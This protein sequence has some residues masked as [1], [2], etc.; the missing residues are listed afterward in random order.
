M[1]KLLSLPLHGKCWRDKN[2]FFSLLSWRWCDR[3]TKFFAHPAGP[4]YCQI[5]KCSMQSEA[6]MRCLHVR[7]N[8]IICFILHIIEA[9]QERHLG[10]KKTYGGKVL[11][12]H[13]RVR[14]KSPFYYPFPREMFGCR[15]RKKIHN[16]L[17][18][19]GKTP[20][21]SSQCFDS[22]SQE[23][24]AAKLS[25]FSLVRGIFMVI[26][27]PPSFPCAL[28]GTEQTLPIFFLRL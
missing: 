4:P 13:W 14:T 2:G 28:P 17:T 5:A 21:L 1:P 6:I 7:L 12:Q 3:R 15:K 8:L 10:N 20:L 11:N 23:E 16:S 26:P 18:K 24:M 22:A 25:P 9:G 27:L 19:M